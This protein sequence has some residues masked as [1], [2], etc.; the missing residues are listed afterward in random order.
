MINY[1][2]SS[3]STLQVTI[4]T[5]QTLTPTI[6]TNNYTVNQNGMYRFSIVLATTHS[7][8]DYL[9]I[10]FPS[11]IDVPASPVCSAYLG[12]SSV[13]CSIVSGK[14]KVVLTFSTFPVD[15]TIAFNI[16]SITNP[17]LVQTATFTI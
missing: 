14:I 7:T 1:L 2:N 10:T 13:A 8:N 17:Q 11:N 5:A 15:K 3:L 12:V 16:S 6:T 9:L 4:T